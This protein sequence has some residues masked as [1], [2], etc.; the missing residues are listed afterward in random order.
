MDGT[1][2][3]E[4]DTNTT[5]S[6]NR[7][8]DMKA[9]KD[10]KNVEDQA[11][12]SQ[13]TYDSEG[14]ADIPNSSPNFKVELIRSLSNV[15]QSSNHSFSPT[16]LQKAQQGQQAPVMFSDRIDDPPDICQ[17]SS[18]PSPLHPV[19]TTKSRE[20]RVPSNPS[21][22]ASS[23]SSR[24][25]LK[26]NFAPVHKPGFH[27]RRNETSDLLK[28]SF[29][30]GY[31]LKVAKNRIFYEGGPSYID[32]SPSKELQ[33]QAQQSKSSTTPHFSFHDWTKGGNDFTGGSN[34]LFTDSEEDGQ[35]DGDPY[36]DV[37]GPTLKD[38]Q[39]ARMNMEM[40]RIHDISVEMDPAC[41]VVKVPIF[42]MKQK[43]ER[44]KVTTLIS[45]F[46]CSIFCSVLLFLFFVLLFDR[47]QFQDRHHLK[48]FMLHQCY[49]H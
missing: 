27:N 33:H 22:L 32:D 43:K 48:S 25:H 11:S 49:L 37:A 45:I 15:S 24:N 4:N 38:L 47:V 41:R 40:G 16:D 17:N 23:S 7:L 30:A 21:S 18:P 29:P 28:N 34:H 26:V 12:V 1:V 13:N 5:L 31:Q 9:L 19:R 10:Q 6:D 39:R 2:I 36:M 14:D 20:K 35:N 3:S 44:I 46:F 42:S 8:S